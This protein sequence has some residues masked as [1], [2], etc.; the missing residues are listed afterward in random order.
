LAYGT[1]HKVILSLHG[2]A[3]HSM[4]NLHDQKMILHGMAGGNPTENKK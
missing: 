2:N 4:A 3:F 1:Q